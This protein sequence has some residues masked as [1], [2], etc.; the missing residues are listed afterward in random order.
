MGVGVRGFVVVD[1][2]VRCCFKR[3]MRISFSN[4]LGLF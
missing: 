1:I 4:V 2:Y 3:F